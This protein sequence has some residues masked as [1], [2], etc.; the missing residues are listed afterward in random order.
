MIFFLRWFIVVSFF[1][2]DFL[3]E[4]CVNWNT[5]KM[6]NTE[7]IYDCGPT[8]C[9]YR[10][11]G[12][13]LW[14]PFNIVLHF[15]TFTFLAFI[16]HATI[17]GILMKKNN[18]LVDEFLVLFHSFTH[19][20]IH[21]KCTMKCNVNRWQCN[22]ALVMRIW[23]IYGNNKVELFLN[24]PRNYTVLSISLSPWFYSSKVSTLCQHF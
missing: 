9:V 13:T 10:L 18:E 23:N 2:P 19:T 22:R 16:L 4:I 20:K 7:C 5:S 11:G 1:F 3:Y 8:L 12:V 17:N 14:H 6:F 15:K 24:E 21:W